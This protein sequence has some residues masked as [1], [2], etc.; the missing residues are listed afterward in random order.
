[1]TDRGGRTWHYIGLA[2]WALAAGGCSAMLP[3][4]QAPTL[5]VT[6][7]E[8]AGGDLQ[9]Q[10]MH[11]T[12]H[13]VNPNAREIAVRGID[14]SFE[15]E[16]Q[17]FAHGSTDAAFT[18]PASGE[19]DFG[20]NVTANLNNAL[21]ALAG[22]FG[23]TWWTIIYTVRFIWPAAWCATSHSIRRVAFAS[24]AGAC[25][26]GVRRPQRSGAPA[27]SRRNPAPCRC[28]P[29]DARPCC[30]DTDPARCRWPT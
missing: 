12:L 27:G 19:T 3:Q 11:L 5:T 1:M 25:A 2:L 21:M 4:L 18:L 6:A 8:F 15:V 23:H 10:Q 9:Q 28:A 24:R 16:G 20:L 22:G 14:C 17:P 29:A 30:R 7:I 26:A 13:V